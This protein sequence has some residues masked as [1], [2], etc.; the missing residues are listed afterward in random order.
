M[1][2][3]QE[4]AMD[5]DIDALS[6]SQQSFIMIHNLAYTLAVQ[7]KSVVSTTQTHASP[8]EYNVNFSTCESAIPGARLP[9]S[10]KTVKPSFHKENIIH[11]SNSIIDYLLAK[12]HIN[13]VR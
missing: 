6:L 3:T 9:V 4:F 12:K 1:K 2:K 11:I 10:S 5:R 13:F 7:N 8:N